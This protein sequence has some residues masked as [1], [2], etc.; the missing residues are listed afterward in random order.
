M[1]ATS[2]SGYRVLETVTDGDT[3]YRWY[4]ITLTQLIPPSYSAMSN[5]SRINPVL[6]IMIGKTEVPLKTLPDTYNA[7]NI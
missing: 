5:Q 3:G 6:F 2:G 1:I 7:V 4:D